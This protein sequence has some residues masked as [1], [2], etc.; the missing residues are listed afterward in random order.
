MKDKI[1]LMTNKKITFCIEG[2]ETELFSEYINGKLAKEIQ[3][4]NRKQ[5]KITG[6][7][8]VNQYYTLRQQTYKEGFKPLESGF[9]TE[10]ED[11]E[12]SQED[13][14]DLSSEDDLMMY[15]YDNKITQNIWLP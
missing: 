11:E 6:Q 1:A 8:I 14:G 2:E 15:E 4:Q 7:T 3:L 9:G 10:S 12:S 13:E 5:R